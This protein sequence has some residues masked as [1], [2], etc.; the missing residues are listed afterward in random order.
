MSRRRKLRSNAR[1]SVP[2]SA[3]PPASGQSF[4][5][6]RPR[7][8]LWL[9]MAVAV[10]ALG[11]FFAL[12]GTGGAKLPDLDLAG[13]DPS[14]VATIE[15]Q[16]G[17]V[18]RAP[19]SGEAWG[20]LGIVLREYGFKSPARE[21]FD[22]AERLDPKNPRWP[23][24]HAVL[25]LVHAPREA[26]GKLCRAVEICGNDPEAPRFRLAKALAED[27]RWADADRELSLLLTAHPEFAPARL[28]QG[29]GARAAGRLP[30]AIGL[31][32]RCAEDPRT[33]RAAWALLA[34]IHR[35]QGDVT[36]AEAASRRSA[37]L[38]NDEGFGDPFEAEAM[39]LRGD[40]RALTEY[41]HPLLAAGRLND[42]TRLVDRL[43]KE[44]PGYPETWLLL[45]RL[46]V[47]RKELPAA[48]RSL[49][50]HLELAPRSAQGWFQLGMA[51]LN[52]NRFP[53]AADAYLRATEIKPDFGPAFF[54]RGVALA[55]AGQPRA[56][57]VAFEATIRHHPEHFESYVLLADLQL[58]LG[59]K[60][61]ALQL[62]ER[63][64]TINPNDRRL[65]GL[66]QRAE[67]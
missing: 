43:V 35:Q 11:L 31:A 26:V 62:L 51:L 1:P 57:V 9:G 6:G 61:E 4:G 10:V 16:L 23:Y 67:R 40:P 8:W 18:K 66:R 64:R 54:N 45:G 34:Q 56:A 5:A 36:A 37:A 42:A 49:R 50:R 12:R 53:D 52:Q 17:G 20:N 7:R 32:Q 3:P 38:P 48:E 21:C 14:V 27:G 33:A 2:G 25:L 29:H 39:L 22:A 55:R 59:G 19:R 47:L 30:E 58:Q 44:H 41:A 63:A 60:A 15:R 13:V 65:A 46:Q 24:A 28:L